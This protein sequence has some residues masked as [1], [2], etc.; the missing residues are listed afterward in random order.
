MD[1]DARIDRL[2]DKQEITECILRFARGVD[3][4]DAELAR[5]AYHEG[6]RDDHAMFVGSGAEVVEWADGLHDQH[7]RSHQHYVANVLIELDGDEAHAESYVIR[8][9][10][11]KDSHGHTLG[12]GRYLDRLERR[13]GEWRIV[14]R[15]LIIEWDD[16][17]GPVAD[18]SLASSQDRE[19]PSYT[20]PLRV[21][22]QSDG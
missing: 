20:R 19:D 13:D 12:G 3:R 21:E 15:V 16:D 7:F 1:R 6:A 11:A 10:G 9:G 22:R 2:L 14:D 18:A 4:H 17:F 5:S 8:V